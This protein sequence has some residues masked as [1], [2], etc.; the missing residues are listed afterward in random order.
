MRN[1]LLLTLCVVVQAAS[2]GG[3]YSWTDESGNLV[4]G[5]SPP[6]SVVAK[7]V[8]P[9]KLTILEN[10]SG[11][12]NT[13]TGV[14]NTRGTASTK[15]AAPAAPSYYKSLTLIAPKAGQVIRA[16]DGDVSVALTVSPKL[17]PGD[18]IV[19]KLDGVEKYRGTQRVANL[20]NLG[21]GTHQLEISIVD[22]ANTVLTSNGVV[23][24]SVLR[25][26]A[27]I[28]KPKNPYL[29]ESNQ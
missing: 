21:R 3:I 15:D 5:D 24:F 18:N 22:R 20:S 11:R 29:I 26:S 8:D 19:M 10:F 13:D 27:L 12:Y 7:P 6:E 9:P 28:P 4:Y 17:R 25:A 14:V 23:S 16:N 1:I 2:A